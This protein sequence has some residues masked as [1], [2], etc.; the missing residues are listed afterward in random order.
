MQTGEAQHEYID[1]ALDKYIEQS[2]SSELKESNDKYNKAL[3]DLKMR[4]IQ[5]YD[6]VEIGTEKFNEYITENNLGYK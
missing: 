5:E 4:F 3:D 6:S 1:K 2:M